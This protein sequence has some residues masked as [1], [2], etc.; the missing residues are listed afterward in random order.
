MQNVKYRIDG[1]KL[2]IEIDKDTVAYE[3]SKSDVVASTGGWQPLDEDP[4][5]AI[6]LTVCKKRGGAPWRKKTGVV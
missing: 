6:N 3:T 1:S 2:I 5:I 4:T